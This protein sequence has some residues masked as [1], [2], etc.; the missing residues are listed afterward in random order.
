[1]SKH[2]ISCAFVVGTLLSTLNSAFAESPR[3]WGLGDLPG[4][5][6]F[7]LA[8][9]VSD[10]GPVVVGSTEDN[11]AV[12]AF[13]WTPETGMQ[14]LNLSSPGGVAYGVSADGNVIVGVGGNHAYRWSDGTSANV[15]I[16]ASTARAASSDGTVVVGDSASNRPGSGVEAYRWTRFG[17]QWLGRLPGGIAST[18]Y[19]VSHDGATIVGDAS[20]SEG[21]RAFRWTQATGMVSLGVLPGASYSTTCAISPD[22]STI[23]GA[24]GTNAFMW[25]STTGMV[26]LGKLAG[27]SGSELSSISANGRIAVGSANRIGQQAIIWDPV[28]GMRLMSDFLSK[29]VSLDLNGWSLM[30]ATDISADGR[31]I[32]GYGINPAGQREGWLAIIPEPGTLIL[33]GIGA[34]LLVR[35]TSRRR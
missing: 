20:S 33:A 3:F 23:V 13:R 26:N 25:T 14:K 32:V 2:P 30:R 28:R 29:E 24:S 31:M 35:R 19:A 11:S 21:Q 6:T 27:S 15:S 8:L 22:G 12:Q 1:M 34:F 7:S 9:A 4:G 16:Y 5:R 18:A 10:I 17:L